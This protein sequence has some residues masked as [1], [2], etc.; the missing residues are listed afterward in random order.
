M[1]GVL[2][3]LALLAAVVAPRRQSIPV[4]RLLEHRAPPPA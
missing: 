1:I 2:F 4:R 3:I